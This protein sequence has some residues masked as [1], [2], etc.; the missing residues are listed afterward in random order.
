MQEERGKGEV[1][2]RL[3]E[4]IFLRMGKGASPP[5]SSDLSIKIYIASK[6]YKGGMPSYWQGWPPNL[7]WAAASC[8]LWTILTRRHQRHNA[9][10]DKQETILLVES[11]GE[12]E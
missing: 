1:N 11:Q 9:K 4:L 3:V 10:S 5:D 2:L 6:V 12:G 8:G 7:E